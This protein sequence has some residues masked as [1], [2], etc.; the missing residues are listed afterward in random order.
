[1]KMISNK[2]VNVGNNKD[3]LK[4]ENFLNFKAIFALI[5]EMNY[6]IKTLE[7]EKEKIM[8]DLYENGKIF[9]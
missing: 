1:M 9:T 3:F 6:Q 2:I 5:Q 8:R 4:S 7:S